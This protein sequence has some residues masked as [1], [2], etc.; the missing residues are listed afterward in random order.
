VPALSVSDTFKLVLPG[1]LLS[2]LEKMY[3]GRSVGGMKL[4]HRRKIPNRIISTIRTIEMIANT[5][6]YSSPIGASLHLYC[7]LW[8]VVKSLGGRD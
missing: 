1:V 3:L 2:T 6:V 7:A 8:K 5:L 4:H